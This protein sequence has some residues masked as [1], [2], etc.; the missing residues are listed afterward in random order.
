MAQRVG[1]FGPAGTYTEEAALRYAPQGDLLPFP[2]IAAVYQAVAE[3][4]RLPFFV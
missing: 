2:S 3:V 4:K 1:Y